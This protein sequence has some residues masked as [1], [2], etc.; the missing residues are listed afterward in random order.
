MELVYICLVWHTSHESCVAI[1]HLKCNLWHWEAE[2]YI[3][4]NCNYSNLNVYS[5]LWLVA[6]ILD[7]AQLGN[8]KPEY[9]SRSKEMEIKEDIQE[10]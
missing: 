4:F 8:L 9:Q 7:N 5:I 6:T 1:E 2:L 3:L 10:L